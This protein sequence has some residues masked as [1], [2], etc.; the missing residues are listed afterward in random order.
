MFFK[1][2]RILIYL[3]TVPQK[4][5]CGWQKKNKKRHEKMLNISVI[6]EMQIK[7]AMRHY[8]AAIRTTVMEK[9]DNTKHWLGCGRKGPY[10][11]YWEC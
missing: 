2:I 9:P 6:R 3:E 7:A 1:L 5:M 11:T 8:H 10:T 4:K